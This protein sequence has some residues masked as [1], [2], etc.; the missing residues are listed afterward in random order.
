MVNKVRQWQSLAGKAGQN[1]R[2]RGSREGGRPLDRGLALV[3]GE[4][5]LVEG[6]PDEQLRGGTRVRIRADPTG[7][8]LRVEVVGEHPHRADRSPAP[9]ALDALAMLGEQVGRA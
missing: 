4:K 9:V 2:D 6:N 1:G 5:P 3:G 7:I 8:A